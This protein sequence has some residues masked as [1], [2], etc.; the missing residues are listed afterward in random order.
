MQI[1]RKILKVISLKRL[2][3][4]N[5]IKLIERK[6][7]LTIFKEKVITIESSDMKNFIRRYYEWL[8]TN[9]LDSLNEKRNSSKMQSTKA[10]K[11]KFWKKLNPLF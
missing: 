2:I 10:D 1:Q 11:K 3:N 5:L 8:Y 6:H 4:Y 9:K 7:K